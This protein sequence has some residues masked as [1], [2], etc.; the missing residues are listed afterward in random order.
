MPSDQDA[1][2]DV[3]NLAFHTMALEIIVYLDVQASVMVREWRYSKEWIGN[4]MAQ[5][6]STI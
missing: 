1:I 4:K 5:I 2:V 3:L 6:L